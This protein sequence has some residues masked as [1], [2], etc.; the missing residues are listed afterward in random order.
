MKIINID[1]KRGDI[2]EQ[3]SKI[4]AYT[5]A[6]GIAAVSA[7]DFDRIATANED[8]DLL[9]RYWAGAANVLADRLRHFISNFSVSQDCISIS[10]QPSGAF[11]HSLADAL[12]NDMA[13]FVT[14]FMAKAW[15]SI[16][17]PEKSDEW[18]EESARL[19]SEISRNIYHRRRPQ[20]HVPGE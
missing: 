18:E 13:S 2:D 7:A 20:R 5:G 9:N 3:L 1:I 8:S 11:D 6:K 15:F 10:L 4:T 12:R 14:A 16:T 17:L 19:L